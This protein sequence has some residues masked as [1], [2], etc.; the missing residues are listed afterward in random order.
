M[1]HAKITGSQWKSTA[2]H[3]PKHATG[4]RDVMT[5]L[6]SMEFYLFPVSVA[7][8]QKYPESTAQNQPHL[9]DCKTGNKKE[10]GKVFYPD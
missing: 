3:L 9:L 6:Q 8:G 5:E 7:G 1:N 4:R 10:S 2:K